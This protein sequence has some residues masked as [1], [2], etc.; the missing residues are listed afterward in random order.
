MVEREHGLEQA[1]RAGR[2]LEVADVRLHRT[3]GDRPGRQTEPSEHLRQRGDLDQVADPGGG[4]VPLDVGGRVGYEPGVLPRTRDGE[5]LADGVG[6]GDALA[7]AVARPADA[8]QHRVDVVAVALGVGEPLEQEDRGSLAHDE[9]VGTVAV[10]PRSCRR[11]CA[12][13]GELDEARRPHVGVDA[14]RDHGV[15]L[16]LLQTLDGRV[17]RRQGRGAGRVDGEVRAV[18]VEQVGH[19]AGDDVAQLAGHGV[20]GDHREPLLRHG[21]H[22]GQQRLAKLERQRGERGCC[23]EHLDVLGQVRPQRCEVVQLAGHRVAEHHRGAVVVER[24]LRVAVVEQCLPRGRHRPLLRA[25]HRGRDLGRH[26]QAPL[27]R[28][29]VE[30]THP[31]TDDRV[32]LVRRVRV[33]VVVEIG[34]PAVGGHVAD[35]AAPLGQVAPVGRDVGSIGQDGPDSHDGDGSGRAGHGLEPPG[36]RSGGAEDGQRPCGSWA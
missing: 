4:A 33:G 20:L 12:D 2:A 28:S 10:R 14:P 31:A 21:R 18:E 19:A 36:G 17:D 24:A 35:G 23:R 11:Q 13:G 26:R 7:L 27:Q 32:R 6:R 29:P 15:V 9:P 1:G 16:T 34:V 22:L 5:L 30:V 3:Q 8:A 25:V